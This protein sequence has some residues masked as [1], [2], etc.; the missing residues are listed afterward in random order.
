M[1]KTCKHELDF[2]K[3]YR[4][5]IDHIECESALSKKI[6]NE[7]DFKQGI[8]F[9]I[10]PEN[11]ILDKLYKFREGEINP[12]ESTGEIH[13]NKITKL[14]F[15]LQRIIT[16]D[17]ELSKFIAKF[18]K[19]NEN[20]CVVIEDVMREPTEKDL[21]IKDVDLAFNGTEVYYI[22]KPNTPEQSIYKAIRKADAIWHFLT[23][24]THG[25]N[26]LTNL[27]EENFSTVLSS[28]NYIVTGAYDGEAHIY[29]EKRHKNIIYD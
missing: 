16:M 8:F 19:K 13:Y 7:I 28:I 14:P 18:L 4:Y 24:L 10:L 3:T 22:L 25:S 1:K 15:I 11:A 21:K 12:P 26:F 17:K 27:T 29:W 20:P 2:E 23:V 9:T 5:F 6:L